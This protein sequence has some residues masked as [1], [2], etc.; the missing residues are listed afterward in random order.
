MIHVSS[1]SHSCDGAFRSKGLLCLC[2]GYL[3]GTQKIMRPPVFVTKSRI[4]SSFGRGLQLSLAMH[5]IVSR[6]SDSE[7]TTKIKERSR[8]TAPSISLR[9]YTDLPAKYGEENCRQ[10]VIIAIKG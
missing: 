1:S 2:P 3:Q 4:S 9:L 5:D 6:D 10:Q 8:A 7:G